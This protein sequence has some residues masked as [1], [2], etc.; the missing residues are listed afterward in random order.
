MGGLELKEEG[1]DVEEDMDQICPSLRR[2]V[3]A[4]EH[5]SGAPHTPPSI[6]KAALAMCVI[7]A[8]GWMDADYDLP[9]ICPAVRFPFR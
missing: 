3:G 2:E 7:A 6:Q 8:R 1:R 9:P 4:Q 5:G